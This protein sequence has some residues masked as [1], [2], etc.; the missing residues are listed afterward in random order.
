MKPTA[1]VFLGALLALLLISFVAANEPTENEIKTDGANQV[2][3]QKQYGGGGYGGGWGGPGGGYGGGWGGPGGGGGWG[4]RGGG[5]WGGGGGGW[6][7]GGGGCRWG[8]CGRNYYGGGCR[9]CYTAQEALAY[10]QTED[11]P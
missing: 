1:Y 6:G 2:V 8:C 7:G 4:G 11:K 10:M 5:G 9:C 3:D